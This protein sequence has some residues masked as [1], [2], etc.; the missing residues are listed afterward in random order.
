MPNSFNIFHRVCGVWRRFATVCGVLVAS[1]GFQ[2]DRRQDGFL[3]LFVEKEVSFVVL[4]L[5]LVLVE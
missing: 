2:A 1:C 5:R 3:G 4:L